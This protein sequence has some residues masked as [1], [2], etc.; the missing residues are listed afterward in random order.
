MIDWS[1]SYTAAWRVF[2]VDEFTWADAELIGDIDSIQITRSCSS[3][4]P[5]L[6]S[7]TMTLTGNF[8]R[9]YYRIVMHATQDV[10]TERVDVATMLCES[11]KALRD[12][13][14]VQPNIA[15]NS[16]LYP[17]YTQRI[18]DGLYIPEKADVAQFVAELLR[19]CL[20][21]PVEVEGGF[22]INEFYWF[23][24][25]IRILE[26]A[27]QALNLGGFVMQ[28]DG[29]GVV[30]IRPRPST[31]A[32]D[33]DGANIALLNQKVQTDFNTSDVPNRYIA[34]SDGTVAIAVNDSQESD[35][36]TVNR[37]YIYDY[38]DDSP[39]TVDNETL[40]QYAIR[41]LHELSTAVCETRTYTRE[42]WPDVYPFDVVR[43][44]LSSI[45]IDGNMRVT[46]QTL[47]CKESIT[48]SEQAAREVDLWQ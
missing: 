11:T 44:S 42:Y 16:V 41:R 5:M 29:R 39:A 45:G 14:T 3:N 30:H 8:E 6:E 28:I 23:E 26:A 10:T 48:V 7:G 34:K 24:F 2:R 27:W 33:L 21:A 4:A 15:C 31:P 25:G 38:I 18:L 13:G 17:A 46:N 36:S 47:S 19:G 37:G 35:V 9:G 20:K 12:Y 1:K 40:P 32:L 43:G 22:T